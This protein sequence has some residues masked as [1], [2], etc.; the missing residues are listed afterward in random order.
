MQVGPIKPTFKAPEYKRLKLNL[1][2][3]LS[4]FAFNINLRHYH[5]DDTEEIPAAG[6]E[7]GTERAKVGRC[8]LTLS[9]PL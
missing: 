7:E 3:L 8:R 2:Q 4:N 5:L 6:A 9:H 1:D